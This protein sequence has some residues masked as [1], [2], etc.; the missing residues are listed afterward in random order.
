MQSLKSLI[1]KLKIHQVG[2][3]EK[4]V[5]ADGVGVKVDMRVDL[6]VLYSLRVTSVL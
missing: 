6:R 2:Q 3:V 4:T 1:L 5:A